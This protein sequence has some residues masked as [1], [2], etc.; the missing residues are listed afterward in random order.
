MVRLDLAQEAPGAAADVEQPLRPAS[1]EGRSERHQ[2][3]APHDGRGPA[4]Q[5]LDLMIIASSRGAAQIPVALKM[6]LLQIIGRVAAIRDFGQTALL[7]RAVPPP[8][9]GAQVS[10]EI[11]GAA[12]RP[13]G[14]V[15]SIRRGQVVAGLDIL[16]VLLDQTPEVQENAPRVWHRSSTQRLRQW[17]RMGDARRQEL[18]AEKPAYAPELRGV[19]GEPVE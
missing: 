9:D 1:G 6:E 16:P 8:L 18:L 11:S 12:Q 14:A 4:E 5:H 17:N 7:A 13:E 15:G 10:E 19:K 2:R 3:L